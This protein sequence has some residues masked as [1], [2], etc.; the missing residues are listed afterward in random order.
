MRVVQRVAPNHLS[1]YLSTCLYPSILYLSIYLC[2][3]SISSHCAWVTTSRKKKRRE[4]R[5]FRH[6]S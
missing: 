5:T 4:K 6:V 2:Y 3:L 1:V